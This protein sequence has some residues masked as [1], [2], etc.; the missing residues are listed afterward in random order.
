MALRPTFSNWKDRIVYLLAEAQ[1]LVAAS[2][3]VVALAMWWF[4]ITLPGL[5]PEATHFLIA[6]LLFGPWLFLAGLKF[7]RWLRTRNWVEVHHVNALHDTIEK[8]YVPPQIWKEKKVNGPDPWPVNGGSAWAVRE[9]DWRPETKSLVVE[10]VW[11]SACSDDQLLTSKRQLHAV[12]NDLLDK[13]LEL[14]G[15]RDSIGK[16]GAEVQEAALN[17]AHIS[18][19]E[20]RMMD[21]DVIRDSIERTREQAQNLGRGDLP[22]IDGQVTEIDLSDPSPDRSGG[23]QRGD[24]RNGDGSQNGHDET[25]E[26]AVEEL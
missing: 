1:L 24:A 21:P 4:G 5:P 11:L 26:I 18:Q 8:Y 3:G 7:S 10:G 9:Y 17:E 22:T 23:P 15:V 6:A 19:E 16:M 25:A 12:Y 2:L 20:G 13:Y 14:G